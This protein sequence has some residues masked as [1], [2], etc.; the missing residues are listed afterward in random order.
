M[1]KSHALR[2]KLDPSYRLIGVF[3]VGNSTNEILTVQ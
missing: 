2:R 1:R 3:L